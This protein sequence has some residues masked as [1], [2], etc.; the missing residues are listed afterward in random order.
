MSTLDRQT[1]WVATENYLYSRTISKGWR[2]QIEHR[3]NS[4]IGFLTGDRP[5]AEVDP[6]MANKW[7]A[8][9]QETGL[10]PD[11]VHGYRAALHAV[12]HHAYLEG[13]T[14]IPPLRLRRI[15]KPPKLVQ[16]FTIAELVALRNAAS[17][18]KRCIEG[19]GVPRSTWW[20]AYIPAAYSTALRR[21][22]LLHIQRS[23]I[24]RDGTVV[25]VAR[26]TGKITARRLSHAALEGIEEIARHAQSSLAFPGSRG[27]RAFYDSFRELVDRAEVSLGTSKWIRRSAASYAEAEQAGQGKL[28]CG[29]SDEWVT[30]RSYRDFKIAPPP[31][32][33][34]P[35]I[36][37]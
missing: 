29:H 9:L 6:I 21:G 28:L 4:F 17:E 35:E 20:R 14:E 3:L 22:C 23:Q 27:P 7:L 12:W 25:V 1:I 24:D 15:Q 8:S 34:P 37:W 16:A 30:N 36:E 5:I 2:K 31:I 32:V 19:T 33:E 11:T 26:K 18:L 10:E 13:W